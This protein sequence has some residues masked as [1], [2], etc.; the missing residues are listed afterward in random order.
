M[1]FVYFDR[2]N[3]IRQIKEDGIGAN[4]KYAKCK[5]TDL[6]IDMIQ[7]KYGKSKIFNKVCEIAD[8]YF[9]DLPEDEITN[10][11]ENKYFD[12]FQKAKHMD[13]SKDAEIKSIRLY[14]SEMRIIEKLADEKLMRL[15]FTLL[16]YS[17]YFR[18]YDYQGIPYVRNWINAKDAEIYADAQFGG[19]SGTTRN[20]LWHQLIQAGLVDVDCREGCD[21]FYESVFRVNFRAEDKEDFKD[22]KLFIEMKKYDDIQLYLR[23]WLKDKKVILC[24]NCGCPI[25]R[26]ERA[27]KLCPECKR[28]RRAKSA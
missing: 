22:E 21:G 25:E 17:K 20:K 16:V 4:D 26:R 1:K 8:D 5:I 28:K 7:K 10:L 3:Y 9:A 6:M 12:A 13:S 23:F 2:E 15:A 24:K 14:E 27:T 19:V 11:L 18:E